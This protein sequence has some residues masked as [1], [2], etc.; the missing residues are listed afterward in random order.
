MKIALRGL[1]VVVEKHTDLQDPSIAFV[2]VGK[3][4]DRE[5]RVATAPLHHGAY[6]SVIRMIEAL[7]SAYALRFEERLIQVHR[8]AF[9]VFSKQRVR[10]ER[11]VWI[12]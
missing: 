10:I 12:D 5:H 6:R 1:L 4:V 2:L 3:G 8:P 9:S 7:D 11:P